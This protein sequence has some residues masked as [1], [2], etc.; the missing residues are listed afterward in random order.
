[1]ATS[2]LNLE[3]QIRRFW[4]IHFFLTAHNFA[5]GPHFVAVTQLWVTET[6]SKFVV[7]TFH[8]H[9]LNPECVRIP[10]VLLLR[11]MQTQSY[12]AS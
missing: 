2:D 7:P 1:M 10:W 5:N 4:E 11:H 3:A 9:I 8:I 12:T 6:G